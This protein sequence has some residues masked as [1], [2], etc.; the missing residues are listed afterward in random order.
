MEDVL[1]FFLARDVLSKKQRI[2]FIHEN[3]TGVFDWEE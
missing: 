3:Y 2:K 1:Y